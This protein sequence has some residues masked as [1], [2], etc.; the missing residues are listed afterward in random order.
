MKKRK[1]A[2]HQPPDFKH[3]PFKS[4]KGFSPQRAGAEQKAPP[5]R[6]KEE[7]EEDAQEIFLQA[8]AGARKIPGDDTP[9]AEP[10][11]KEM[12][13]GNKPLPVQEEQLFLQA[14]QKIGTSIREA[15]RS[16]EEEVDREH[17]SPGSRMRRLKRGAIRIGREL[18]L[19]GFLRDEAI[20][21]LARFITD[22]FDRGLEAVLVITGKGYNSPEGPVLRG[23][24]AEW[25]MHW[26]KS[27]VA[28][29]SSAPPD[30]GGSGAFVVFLKKK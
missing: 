19:H 17:R 24:V 20:V 18:D 2:D 21:Q 1:P 28:E 3:T 25:L 27:M 13:A 26:G 6:E 14:M 23:A 16:D 8:V 5:T 7:K 10:V 12:P 9:A 22:A 29:F 4:L 11:A 15:R 30:K